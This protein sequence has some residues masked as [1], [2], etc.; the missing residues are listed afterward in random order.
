MIHND[1]DIGYCECNVSVSSKLKLIQKSV[2]CCLF[3][4]YLAF[5]CLFSIFKSSAGLPLLLDRFL[6]AF[7][8]TSYEVLWYSFYYQWIVEV[9]T[10]ALVVNIGL[11]GVRYRKSREGLQQP[12][13]ED[14]LQKIP[15]ED[16][17]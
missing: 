10:Y 8:V 16:E 5:S 17:G 14:V 13:L 2:Q 7:L 6:S 15:Q 4:C 9:H 11:S 12:P 1:M 3:V